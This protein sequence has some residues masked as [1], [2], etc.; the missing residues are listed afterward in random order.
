MSDE[1][2][3]SLYK[4]PDPT[5]YPQPKPKRQTNAPWGADTPSLFVNAYCEW[6]IR[7]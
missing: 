7:Q 5:R 1:F 6:V 2:G 3:K 4:L